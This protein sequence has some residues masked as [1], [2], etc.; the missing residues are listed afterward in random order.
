MKIWDAITGAGIRTL[1][2]RTNTVW[3]VAFSPDGRYVAGGSLDKT[4]K[5]WDAL[6]GEQLNTLNGHEGPVLAVAFSPDGNR[7]ASAGQRS[8]KGIE[9]KVWDVGTGAQTLGFAP[10]SEDEEWNCDIAFSPD[11]QRI[12]SGL[13]SSIMVWNS[14]T[15]EEVL[16]LPGHRDLVRAAAFS[17]DGTSIASGSV[18]GTVKLWDA[19]FQEAALTLHGQ[20]LRFSPDGNQVVAARR[21]GII[22][23]W[24]VASGKES[25]V[26]KGHNLSVTTATFS[27]DGRQIASTGR[28]RTVKVAGSWASEDPF[29]VAFD[30]D[31]VSPTP[32]ETKTWDEL[33]LWNVA[34][35]IANFTLIGP[36]STDGFVGPVEFSPNSERIA[37]V[38]RDHTV[39]VANAA[40]GD[41]VVTLQGHT[42]RVYCVKFSP[43]S[44]RIVTGSEDKTIKVWDAST[45]RALRT[46]EGHTKAV[47]DIAF[48]PGGERL[49]SRSQDAII[50]W[51]LS[52]GQDIHS[53]A[54]HTG[55]V[56]DVAFSPDG[57]LIASGGWDKTVRLWDA[58]TGEQLLT[59]NAHTDSVSSV[60]FDPQGRRIVS[61]SRDGSV[62]LL[63]VRTGQEALTLGGD[64]EALFGP[65]F[66]PQGKVIVSRSPGGYGTFKVWD[67]RLPHGLRTSG[68]RRLIPADV[69]A[70]GAGW[71]RF[72]VTSFD[73]REGRGFG[74]LTNIVDEL[75]DRGNRKLRQLAEEVAAE[76]KEHR[77][78]KAGVMLLSV[79]EAGAGNTERAAERVE[80]AL[81]DSQPIP[82]D[83]AWMFGL[84][85][86]GIVGENEELNQMVMR[87]YHSLAH[88]PQDRALR[89]SPLR[90]LARLY[91]RYGRTTEA[92][93]LLSR[94][95]E[96]DY[97][98]GVRC[99]DS[100]IARNANRCAECHRR[101]RN[102]YD[103]TVM[104]NALTDLGYPVD[105][106]LLLARIDSSFGNIYAG[107][108][109][110]AR[111]TG[112]S[113]LNYTYAKG[114][115]QEAKRRAEFSGSAQVVLRALEEGVFA[116]QAATATQ[117]S[118]GVIDLQLDVR[119]ESGG[120]T[121]FSPVVDILELAARKRGD[122]DR[123]ANKEVDEKL[124][125]LFEQHPESIEA[126]VL[127]TV[128]A[129]LRHDPDAAES[130]LNKLQALRSAGPTD[131]QPDDLALWLVAR[132]ALGD[133]RTKA[134]GEQ[135]ANIALAAAEKQSDSWWRVAIL[136]ERDQLT[137]RR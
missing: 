90:N 86:E 13:D 134:V 8:S 46:L 17:P 45:G 50:L 11:G 136:R 59:F 124:A 41:E 137:K 72:A 105:A 44:H 81:A 48:Q 92:R 14:F 75:Y 91:G 63:D 1:D 31:F 28:G 96:V 70:E 61:G 68:I 131:P 33:T 38:R 12:V 36:D 110:W 130:R 23:I 104:S 87:L 57:T 10:Q 118:G 5:L 132:R 39:M 2:G 121:V 129:F 107:T 18:D 64:K 113:G 7:L 20:A 88:R 51:D 93:Q 78:W 120:A 74:V 83:A 79:L 15:G 6:T 126:G 34:T 35:G 56:L 27:P 100:L 47:W 82:S 108:E 4:V 99:S 40:T 116:R 123:A 55:A 106:L 25:L 77:D 43:D 127:A 73:N 21:D 111:R 112:R 37:I 135:L 84:A 71:E 115:F 60:D 102:L 67:A 95:A 119:G 26:L 58:F 66:G 76:I 9:V 16:T 128:S 98:F 114:P 94:L 30:G 122:E 133:N 85:L 29:A 65:K 101:E 54:G 42:A 89:L 109:D 69:E 52:T 22:S 49:I 3:D 97:Q 24:D 32:L 125:G 62:K 19:T 53:L 80:Q 117:G 103:F